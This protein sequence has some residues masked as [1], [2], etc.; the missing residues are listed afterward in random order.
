MIIAS[1]MFQKKM[2][3]GLLMG[4]VCYCANAYDKHGLADVAECNVP[5]PGKPDTT[6]GGKGIDVYETGFS[7]QQDAPAETTKAPE[8]QTEA[9]SE[10][11]EA[12]VETTQVP[13]EQT[14]APAEQT[15]A[16]DEQTEGPAE[17]TQAPVETT[18][19]P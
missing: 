2:Y 6:C 12:P 4:K 13:A 15:E 1:L 10:Q 16:P 9:P 17:A 3:A 11:T 8:E 5:C 18:E 7:E 19:A 14:E